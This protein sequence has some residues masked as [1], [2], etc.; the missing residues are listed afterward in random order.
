MKKSNMYPDTKTWNPFVG[1]LFKCVYC[2]PSF[3]VQL[4][5][6][7]KKRDP[8]CYYYRPHLHPER[9]KKIPSTENVFVVGDGDISFCSPKYTRRIIQRIKE[10][11]ARF[12]EK[13]RT[14]L[15]QS[16]NPKYFQQFLKEFPSNVIL[17]TTL[18][19][20]RDEGYEKWSNA[21]KPSV[22]YKDFIAL[23]YPR[24][25]VTV[26]P[27]LD[28]DLDIFADWIISI[29]PEYVWFGFN[30]KPNARILKE[31]RFDKWEPSEEKA[32]QLIKALESARKTVYKHNERA[33][34]LLGGIQVKGK[35]LGNVKVLSGKRQSKDRRKAH[36]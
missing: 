25:V 27:A 34:K 28:F 15:F 19:T 30:S 5:R 4:K 32:Q 1:C 24:K 2:R 36:R 18:E 9:L 8:D 35:E 12:P 14:Y 7:G 17:Q 31:K 21:P 3:Q 29:K 22:R 20:N 26:E 10:Q 23:K 11:N 13:K 6:R 16:K 33:W